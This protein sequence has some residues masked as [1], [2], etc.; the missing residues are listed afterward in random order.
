MVVSHFF[1][2]GWHPSSV[3]DAISL[4]SWPL[5]NHTVR[6]LVLCGCRGETIFGKRERRG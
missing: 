5:Y 1:L 2:S 6:L 3:A 4:V